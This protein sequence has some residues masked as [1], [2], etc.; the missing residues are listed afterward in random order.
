MREEIELDLTSWMKSDLGKDKI[1]KKSDVPHCLEIEQKK[2][3]RNNIKII[4]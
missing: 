1:I 3:F 2:K 4:K